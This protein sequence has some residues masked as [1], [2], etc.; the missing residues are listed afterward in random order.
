LRAW[1]KV[2]IF[3]ATMAEEATVSGKSEQAPARA[4]APATVPPEEE[5]NSPDRRS[6]I[7][8]FV[9][10]VVTTLCWGAA[11]FA[12]NMHP[13]E[14]RAAPKLTT[15]RLILTPKD[16]AIE[17]VQRWRSYDYEGALA[18]VT[19]DDLTAELNKAKADCAAK[20]NDCARQREAA[21]G[22]LTTAVVLAQ[23]GFVADTR[24]ASTLKGQKETYRVKL[25]REGALWKAFSKSSE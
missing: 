21:A 6:L 5:I 20:A 7:G 3:A 9:I 15:D 13:P 25:R 16:A 11:R 14:S 8:L 1:P 22:R 10:F 4:A 18:T 23:D 19:G 24:V 12:C 17:Y 2:W